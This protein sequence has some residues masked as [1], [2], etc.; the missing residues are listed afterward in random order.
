[1][2]YASSMDAIT[3][4]Q[5]GLSHSSD[6][7][8]DVNARKHF[9]DDLYQPR[10]Q[11]AF[12]GQEL[13]RLT[14]ALSKIGIRLV[15]KWVDAANAEIEDWCRFMC[16][17]AIEYAESG[18][19]E[20]EMVENEPVVVRAL[21]NGIEKEESKSASV[22][23]QRI[24]KWKHG[25][26]YTEMLDHLAAGHETS[27]ITLTYAAYYL[28]KRPELQAGL[29]KEL[30]GLEPPILFPQEGGE[31]PDLPNPKTIDVLPLLNA[32]LT[33]TLRLNAAIP[34]S[35]PRMTPKGGCKLVGKDIPGGVRVSSAAWSLH[36][37][38]DVFAKPDV[39]D[40]RRWL[41][42]EKDEEG[43]KERERWFWAFSSGGR[44]CIGNNF[45]ILREWCFLFCCWRRFACG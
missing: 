40:H 27:G 37:N 9:L 43:R 29:R 32:I 45:A 19:A 23:E 30:M 16:D 28:S 2:F 18:P 3:A 21:L 5:F 26:V 35:T 41:V 38:A 33:E 6:M 25:M 11:Y 7:I 20:E 44:M 17:G 34:G 8:R 22:L 36:R 14:K 4:Y 13:P 10:K 12:F 24:K 31:L 15:P 42:D 39:W 1:M